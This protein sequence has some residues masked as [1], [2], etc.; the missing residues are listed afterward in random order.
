MSLDSL[1][2]TPDP[3]K[4]IAV[5]VVDGKQVQ[6][7]KPAHGA[8]G[9]ATFTSL[10]NPM[11]AAD[12]GGAASLLKRIMDLLTSPRGYDPS[13]ARQRVTAAIESGVVT[14]VTTVTTCSTVSNIAAGTINTVQALTNI[15]G[16]PGAMLINQTNLSAWADCV[17]SR[18]T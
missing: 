6:V 18:I 14:T 3:L 12:P 11:P 5:D 17:R 7:M 4:D 13:L 8:N 15:D 9:E 2:F 10:A 1:P 16:R